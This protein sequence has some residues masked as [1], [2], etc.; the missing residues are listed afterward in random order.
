M[1]PAIGKYAPVTHPAAMETNRRAAPA[2]GMSIVMQRTKTITSG[3]QTF[4][5]RFIDGPPSKD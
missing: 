2:G 1:A 4:F 3:N 5:V